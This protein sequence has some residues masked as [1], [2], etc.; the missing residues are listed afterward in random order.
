MNNIN[1]VQSVRSTHG[2]SAAN[3]LENLGIK[4]PSLFYA[5]D[6]FHRRLGRGTDGISCFIVRL[7]LGNLGETRSEGGGQDKT[8]SCPHYKSFLGDTDLPRSILC[9]NIRQSQSGKEGEGISRLDRHRRQRRGE[10]S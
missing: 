9:D 5:L 6:W 8:S 2:M 3:K 7:P 4:N 1:R 10:E